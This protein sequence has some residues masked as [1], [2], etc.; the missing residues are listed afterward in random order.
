MSESL[1]AS[2]TLAAAGAT[3]PR[4]TLEDLNGSIAHEHYFIAGE[5]IA[6]LAGDKKPDGLENLAGYTICL[7]VL[8]NGW[9]EMGY[10][11]PASLENFD[12]Q[13]G[14]TFAR[15]MAIRGLWPK[16]GLCLR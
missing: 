4:V 1:A 3:H 7:L 8:H 15:E 16:L 2:E 6:A 9:V 10:S 11:A 5:A 13:K 12:P 14:M